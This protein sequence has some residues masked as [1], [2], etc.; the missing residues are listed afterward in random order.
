[1][2]VLRRVDFACQASGT[3]ATQSPTSGYPSLR[4]ALPQSLNN[5]GDPVITEDVL[6]YNNEV[7]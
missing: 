3:I 5:I 2:P 1:M 7:I 6:K 4:K